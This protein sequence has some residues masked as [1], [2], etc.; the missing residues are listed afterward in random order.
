MPTLSADGVLAEGAFHGRANLVGPAIMKAQV[1]WVQEF[2][3]ST[4]T[5]GATFK[6]SRT[7]QVNDPDVAL[8]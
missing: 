3:P 2:G 6:E 8:L 4:W 1:R 5:V 7:V